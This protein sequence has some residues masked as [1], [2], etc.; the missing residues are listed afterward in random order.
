L[1][2]ALG[3][4]PDE[5]RDAVLQ[6]DADEASPAAAEEPGGP[7]ASGDTSLWTGLSL[8]ARMSI[9]SALEASIDLGHTC[10]S[11]RW[12]HPATWTSSPSATPFA[13]IRPW[14]RITRLSSAISLCGS[15]ASATPTQITRGPSCGRY[16][17]PPGPAREHSKP[18]S[19]TGINTVHLSGV[20]E[21]TGHALAGARQC[22]PAE[23][24]KD[25]VKSLVSG[26]PLDLRFR[27][28][29]QLAIDI[30]R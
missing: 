7:S 20:R 4:D 10:T 19:R 5:L 9:A 2:Q 17:R 14:Q 30:P 21:K 28:K 13:A 22:I 1:L 23:D 6:I 12:D 16:L 8:P 15:P 3:A 26:L 27:T 25:P 18:G 24:I 11:S 29:G